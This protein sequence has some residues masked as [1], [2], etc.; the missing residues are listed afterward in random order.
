M[1]PEN[2]EAK[3]TQRQKKKMYKRAFDDVHEDLLLSAAEALV[4][5]TALLAIGSSS[6]KE[7]ADIALGIVVRDVYGEC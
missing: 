1:I 7:I 4:Y 3:M 2:L 5:K 6:P